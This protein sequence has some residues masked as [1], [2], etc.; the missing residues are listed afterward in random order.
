MASL[1]SR[2]FRNSLVYLHAHEHTHTLKC[3]VDTLYSDIECK[4]SPLSPPNCLGKDFFPPPPNG[5]GMRLI[6]DLCIV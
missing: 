5:L 2:A 3:T 1:I 4:I 6:V